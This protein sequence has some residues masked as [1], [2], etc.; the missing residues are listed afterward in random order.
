MEQALQAIQ[1]A[2]EEKL[3]EL[4]YENPEVTFEY[5]KEGGGGGDGS[6]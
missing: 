2:E 4:I 6:P 1:T 3:D 5:F